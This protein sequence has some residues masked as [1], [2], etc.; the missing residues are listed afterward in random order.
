M[1]RK[2]VGYIELHWRC[3]NCG[4]QN[5]GSEK[6]CTS[7]GT[8]QPPDVEFYQ[9]S[10]AELLKDEDK[11]KAAQV[12][13]DV[14]C[15]YCGTRNSADASECARCGGDLIDAQ[16]RVKGKILGAFQANDGRDQTELLCPSCNQANASSVKYC[17]HCGSPMQ[18]PISPNRTPSPVSAIKANPSQIAT[19]MPAKKRK[20]SPIL[21]IVLILIAVG[22]V[23]TLLLSLIF[24]GG[25]NDPTIATVSS[26]YWKA[27]IDIEELR[28]VKQEAWWDK[29]PD[30][31]SNVNCEQELYSTSDVPTSGALEV[32]G[33]PY[34]VDL[35]N[36]N[37][38]IVQDCEYQTYEDYCT[39]EILDWVV[40]DTIV[41]EGYDNDPYWTNP[42]VNA[43]QIIGNVTESYQVEFQGDGRFFDYQPKDLYEFQLLKV[44]TTWEIEQGLFGSIKSI[45]AVK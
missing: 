12:G 39:F 27:S 17:V 10:S 44:G 37:A 21:L 4:T 26:V 1:A 40:V 11:I 36:G 14:H 29:V 18:E 41:Y 3:S 16:Q 15:P 8:P 42:S 32:C 9:L 7:C 25:G 34:S 35:G 45:T 13:P 30:D 43:D 38:E 24:G 23:G 20:L 28:Y 2:V 31:A 22:C 19:A 6:S 33:D 5:P